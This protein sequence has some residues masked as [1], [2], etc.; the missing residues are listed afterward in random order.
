MVFVGFF[1]IVWQVE[2]TFDLDTKNDNLLQRL[3]LVANERMRKIAM[4]QVLQQDKNGEVTVKHSSVTTRFYSSP[5]LF[6]VAGFPSE[7]KK[8]LHTNKLDTY[9]VTLG[10]YYT[11]TL[12]KVSLVLK[13]VEMYPSFKY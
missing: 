4:F 13:Y 12:Q 3:K 8:K 1:F 11:V 7:K 9:F 10:L 2:K 6:F 5:Q